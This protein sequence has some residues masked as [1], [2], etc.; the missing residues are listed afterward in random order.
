MDDRLVTAWRCSSDN[1]DSAASTAAELVNVFGFHGPPE[2]L[3][4]YTRCGE[5]NEEVNLKCPDCDTFADRAEEA[6]SNF[7]PDYG[8]AERRLPQRGRS[9]AWFVRCLSCLE[10]REEE[11]RKMRDEEEAQRRKEEEE[12]AQ[13]R[14]EEEEEEAQRKKEE[15]EQEEEQKKKKSPK[16]RSKGD[17]VVV[18]LGKKDLKKRGQQQEG[19]G[20]IEVLDYKSNKYEVVLTD[21]AVDS[22]L[23]EHESEIAAGIFGGVAVELLSLILKCYSNFYLRNVQAGEKAK[24]VFYSVSGSGKMSQLPVGDMELKELAIQPFNAAI[25]DAIQR[26]LVRLRSDGE[27]GRQEDDEEELLALPNDWMVAILLEAGENMSQGTPSTPKKAKTNAPAPPVSVGEGEQEGKNKKIPRKKASKKTSPEKIAEENTPNKKRTPK[28]SA[29][30]RVMEEAE[31]PAE[32][33]VSRFKIRIKSPTS[34]E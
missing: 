9:K 22:V 33:R 10:R 28:S 11:Q 8:N 26:G 34:K 3:V 14:K 29:K 7:G 32:K 5:C 17:D 15:E 20:A 31:A 30:R 18:E 1:C 24:L 6:E 19:D 13:R 25:K 23:E 16:N 21:A 12:E 2:S 27:K 4:F